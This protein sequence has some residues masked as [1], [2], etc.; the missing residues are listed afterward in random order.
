MRSFRCFSAIVFLF[1]L[2][3][4][5]WATRINI[6][7]P[8]GTN[9]ITTV[10]TSP[11]TV[12]F[13]KTVC[14]D[15]GPTDQ[16]GCFAF[17][18]RTSSAW[19]GLELTLPSD[20]PSAFSFSC[21]DDPSGTPA[22]STVSFCG[23]DASKKAYDLNFTGGTIPNSGRMFFEITEDDL[24]PSSLSFTATPIL[25]STPEPSGLLLM[26]TGVLCAGF[27]LRSRRRAHA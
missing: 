20:D 1:A 2:A 22:F 10:R 27:F 8:T 24:D 5:A 6:L 11:F 7:D 21:N 16:A 12:D 9:D 25:A 15:L 17:V 13:S 18:N 19:T 23:Y 3:S 26:G 14:T 4:S